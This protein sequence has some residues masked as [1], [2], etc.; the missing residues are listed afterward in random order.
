MTFSAGA[1]SPHRDRSIDLV[2]AVLLV[3]VVGLHSM[4][5]GISVGPSG[6]ALGNA[7][8]HQDWF[9][10]V[11]WV[12]QVMPLFFLVGGF[13]SHTQWTRMRERGH[14]ASDYVVSRL[15][16]LLVPAVVVIVAVAIGLAAM[17]ALGVPADL[18]AVAGFRISQPLWFLGVYV[19]C[20]AFVPVLVAAHGKR[21]VLTLA[22]LIAA[23]VA[24]DVLRFGTG[25]EGIGFLN[26]VFV[27][28]AVQQLGF[29]L[30]DGRFDALSMRSRVS[31]MAGS[32]L[33]L[34]LLTMLGPYSVDMLNNLNPPTICLIVLGAAQLMLFTLLRDRLRLA[35]ERP[36][37]GAVVDALGARSMTVYL[38]H[39]PVIIV[40]AAGLL[41]L[42]AVVHLPLPEP[43]SAGWWA[44]RPIWL[45]AVGIAVLPVAACLGRFE[46]RKV[47]PSSLGTS[48]RVRVRVAFAVV[49]GAGAVLVLLVTGISLAGAV[50]ALGMFVAALA[51]AGV[52]ERTAQQES[53]LVSGLLSVR[54]GRRPATQ[55]FPRLR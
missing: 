15:H 33:G 43:L 48:P 7:L 10:P 13:S 45:L 23:A 3:I 51:L 52:L 36:R 55:G 27:W 49:A 22:S 14:S 16:R 42:N 44:T 5:V 34:L 1:T 39:M 31:I 21:P 6:F 26:L 53:G 4:M 50:M 37:I 46:M 38:W 17:T 30:A 32:L 40:L 18:I 41:V 25:I 19:L 9:A 29:W 2:R 12:L 35:A 54:S 20:S 47:A 8:E 28:L 11:T 24:V